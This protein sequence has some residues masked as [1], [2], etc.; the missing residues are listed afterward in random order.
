MSGFS[1]I[2]PS[3]RLSFSRGLI[4]YTSVMQKQASGNNLL[5]LFGIL[6]TLLVL[7]LIC[8]ITP[9]FSYLGVDLI[10]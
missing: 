9:V 2:F 8:K 4:A 7:S 1:V 6:A 5:G 10:L 3:L